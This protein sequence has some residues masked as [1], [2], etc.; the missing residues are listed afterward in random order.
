[1]MPSPSSVKA[2]TIVFSRPMLSE[3]QPNI[4][5]EM[6]FMMRSSIS[7]SGNTAITKK[8]R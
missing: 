7:A 8:W 6:P 3:I 5:R 2:I 4:R 1:M